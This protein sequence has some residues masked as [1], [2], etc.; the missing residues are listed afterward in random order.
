[1]L[2]VSMDGPSVNWK[3]LDNLNKEHEMQYDGL[4]LLVVGSCGL[5]TLH[6]A[7]K[8]GFTMWAME[9]LLRALHYLFRNVPARRE[10]Y[11]SLTKSSIFPLP[12]CGHRWIE[13]APVAERAIEV[14]PNIGKYVTAEEA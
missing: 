1:M 11:V 7:L 13:N 3:F 12:F 10:D 14:W 6:N 2:S 4:Q 9:K 8:S 5:H